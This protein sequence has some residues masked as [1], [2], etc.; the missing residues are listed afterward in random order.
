MSVSKNESLEGRHEPFIESKKI[1]S[2]V[3]FLI[4]RSANLKT[5]QI[6]ARAPHAML[7]LIATTWW[8]GDGRA[9]SVTF[10]SVCTCQWLV[11]LGIERSTDN[12]M[13]MP[14]MIGKIR[15]VWFWSVLHVDPGV[16]SGPGEVGMELVRFNWRCGGRWGVAARGVRLVMPSSSATTCRVSVELTADDMFGSTIW[17]TPLH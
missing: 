14:A 13:S 7:R 9:S 1:H 12:G 11:K 6:F 17:V 3:I 10:P 8:R 2:K 5:R 15:Y 4:L 16:E